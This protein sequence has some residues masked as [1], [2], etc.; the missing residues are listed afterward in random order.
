MLKILQLLTEK[1]KNLYPYRVIGLCFWFLTPVTRGLSDTFTHLRHTE[2]LDRETPVPST[3][4][5]PGRDR[6][7]PTGRSS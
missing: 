7:A 6:S 1:K 5:V 2:T 4:G 3:T